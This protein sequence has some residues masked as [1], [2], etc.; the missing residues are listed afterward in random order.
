[1][2]YIRR[3][4]RQTRRL[5]LTAQVVWQA[6]MPLVALLFF[7]SCSRNSGLL[8]DQ[9]MPS[10]TGIGF[11]NTIRETEE[12][13]VLNYAY[14]YN[15]GGV[16]IGDLNNDGLPDILFTGNMSPNRLYLN[17]GHFKFEDITASSGIAAAQGWCTGATLADVNGDGLLDI[18]ICRSGDSDPVRRRNLLYINL[19]NG[20]FRE[21]AMEYGLA[22]EGY[23]T[24]AVFF[25]YDRDGDLDMFLANHS[26]Q[27]Y[28]RGNETA[29]M[30]GQQSAS[31]SDKL[32]RNDNGHF[33]DV[34]KEAGIISNVLTFGLGVTVSDFNND[35]WP[36]IY[37]SND[38]NEPDYLFM[39]NGLSKPARQGAAPVV[40]FTESLHACMDQASLYSMG[41]DA[42]DFDNDG[43]I[44]LITLDMLPEDNW[45]QKMHTGAENFDKFQL[46]F[47]QGMYPQYSRN[48]LHHNNGDGSFSE[49]G[50]MAGVSNTD[51]SWSALFADF[52]NDGNKDLFISSGY[53]KDNTNMDFMK[54][55]LSQQMRARGDALSPGLIQD[56][57]DKMP[58]MPLPSYLFRN[59]GNS[60][61]TNMARQWGMGIPGVSAGAAYADLDNDGD[62][63]L[64]VNNINQPAGI[65]RNNTSQVYPSNHY[66]TVALKGTGANTLGV[67]ARVSVYCQ[68]R[69]YLQE[70]YT[71]RG[72]Q[73]SVDPVLTF[74]LGNCVV[75]DSVVVSWENGAITRQT[76]V[77]ANQRI[78][79]D[80]GA[81]ISRPSGAV[82]SPADASSPSPADLSAPA[83]ARPLAAPAG[84]ALFTALPGAIYVHHEK[85]FNDFALQPLLSGYLSRNGPCM[86][87][88]D[89]NGDGLEDIFIGGGK[90]HPGLI[91]VQHGEGFLPLSEPAVSADS[92][93]EPVAAVFFD[94]DA[95]G[96]ADLYVAYGGY[97]ATANGPGLQ[98]CL[99][100]NDGKGHFKK[101]VQSLPS[102]RYNKQCIRVADFDHD[103]DPDIFI[104]GGVVPG[105]YP[106]ADPSVILLNDGK[107]HFTEASDAV[108][109][110]L[111]DKGLVNDA[112]W[113]DLNKDGYPDLIVVGMWMSVTV[114]INEQGHFVDR[115]AQYV[116]FPSS[117]W[118]NSILASDLDGDGNIDLIIG[119]QGLNNQ[120]RASVREPLTVYTLDFD[121]NGIA[122]PVLSYF[123]H[124]TAYPVYSR[125]DL[126][127]HL[128]YLKK[129]FP[130]YHDYA[131]AGM[132]DI[133]GDKLQQAMVHQATQLATLYLHNNGKGAFEVRPLPSEVQLSPI[134][135][136]LA[137]DLNHDG[138]PDL[139]LCGNNA[140]TRIK[141]GRYRANH[142][143]V[144]INDG[145][146]NFSTMPQQG[147]AL[148]LRGDVRSMALVHGKGQVQLLV[149]MNNDSVRRYKLQQGPTQQ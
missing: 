77:T 137:E 123:I 109:A 4:A 26:L 131:R 62:M 1:M 86:A 28:A 113:V 145:K 27:Q 110:S 58:P 6:F 31:F 78:V 127:D 16:A 92:L 65:F 114:L 73:S 144:L 46:L 76:K 106:L 91:A 89:I 103:G 15:G 135:A 42:A 90:G 74:G 33:T 45:S 83:A 23:S 87:K 148:H 54:Y 129:K 98:D 22:D 108:I 30:R 36:D 39:N 107:G 38:F 41:C 64:V 61:F 134:Y 43:R 56:L 124:D 140:W 49:M 147:S 117:G 94:A 32:Y 25:D 136:T 53:A 121:G 130:E 19:G 112:V 48:M 88:A 101:A 71:V 70:A 126:M 149:G 82:L 120:F 95:D 13:N 85:T 34:S 52:D 142:G 118:W 139:I 50:Q 111:K 29:A 17:K 146:G 40:T 2:K 138:R 116:P 55:R 59:D 143:L 132:T 79:I 72:F 21:A 51:W 67:G 47:N 115:S 80:E 96:D 20:K 12:G 8:F 105:K 102:R 37:V 100:L 63:D 81:T 11:V 68:G 84:P 122:D 141:F 104:G 10:E 93:F 97:A 60:H 14:F 125:D 35:G 44:D 66:L 128:P 119:N 99:Y 75:A 57:I 24:Q 133:F 69:Q 3:G 9:L 7:G 18:Y 5:A